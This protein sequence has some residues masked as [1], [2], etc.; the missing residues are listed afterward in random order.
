[1]VHDEIASCIEGQDY[2]LGAGRAVEADYGA[3]T[4]VK[5]AVGSVE[6][7][8]VEDDAGVLKLEDKSGEGAGAFGD[9]G[10]LGDCGGCGWGLD[11][12]GGV[13]GAYARAGAGVADCTRTCGRVGWN[14]CRTCCYLAG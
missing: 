2:G 9:G 14:G 7:D 6:I 8:A 10:G 12:G 13:G 1:M 3:V 11:G 5:L 4:I